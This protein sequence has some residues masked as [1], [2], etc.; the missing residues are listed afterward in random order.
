MAKSIQTYLRTAISE[1]AASDATPTFPKQQMKSNIAKV[2]ETLKANLPQKLFLTSISCKILI[3]H[4]ENEANISKDSLSLNPLDIDNSPAPQV[5][6][7]AVQTT[8]NYINIASVKNKD[9]SRNLP[10]NRLFIR[11][12]VDQILL[13]HVHR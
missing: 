9:T 7:N 2:S 6:L 13:E 12:P 5:S 10:D 8:L 11:L 3:G 4:V 1:F